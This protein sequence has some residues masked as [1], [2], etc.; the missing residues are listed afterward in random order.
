MSEYKLLLQALK[1]N[2]GFQCQACRKKYT[3]GTRKL[4]VHHILPRDQG[5]NEEADNLILLCL[6][7]HDK[8]EENWSDYKCYHDIAYVFTRGGVKKPHKPKE[9]GVRWQQ[10]V[11]GGYDRPD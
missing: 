1:E 2:F 4:T 11:Y 9:H 5:G 3:K 7:C 8:I 6:K 10:W